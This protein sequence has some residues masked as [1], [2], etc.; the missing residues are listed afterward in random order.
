MDGSSF[1]AKDGS[2][3]KTEDSPYYHFNSTCRER[4]PTAV[5][6]WADFSC[7]F[8][9]AL[10]KLPSLEATVYR[11]LNIPLTQQS[12]EYKQGKVVWLVSATSTTSDRKDTLKSFG[13]GTVSR[14]GTLMEIRALFAKDIQVFSVFKKEKELLLAPNTCLSIQEAFTSQTLASL[15]R[16]VENM[17]ENVD[18]IVAHQQQ[19]SS[20]D[21]IA[22][23][24]KEKT[25]LAD[26]QTQQF[27][28]RVPPPSVSAWSLILQQLQAVLTNEAIASISYYRSVNFAA[29]V[30]GEMSESC[31]TTG[32]TAE[33]ALYA[34]AG[35]TLHD[36]IAAR[37]SSVHDVDNSLESAVV[38]GQ[39]VLPHI[40]EAQE[41]AKA[42]GDNAKA[43]ELQKLRC[44]NNTCLHHISLTCFTGC[45]SKKLSKK[46]KN[47][48]K[49]KHCGP[50]LTFCRSSACL[51]IASQPT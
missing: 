11:G 15:K 31:S 29:S 17:P 50:V 22:A 36:V 27:L 14:P 25:D 32:L 33:A 41:A 4:N 42:A 18:L 21:I 40:Q 51:C 49:R 48:K 3:F 44:F 1:Q 8:C 26:F 16:L 30:C 34:A 38:N 2:N 45:P 24:D 12:H 10:D 28:I 46:L 9:S 37:P 47:C 39:Q 23:Q 35:K 43:S 5:E 13:A 19:V 7:L 6:R 20:D